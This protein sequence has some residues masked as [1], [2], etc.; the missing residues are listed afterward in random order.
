MIFRLIKSWPHDAFY[1]QSLQADKWVTLFSHKKSQE[2]MEAY[3][4][5]VLKFEDGLCNADGVEELTRD[6]ID[7]R[8]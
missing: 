2:A 3:K 4:R 6:D 7:V 5:I 1:I 8:T